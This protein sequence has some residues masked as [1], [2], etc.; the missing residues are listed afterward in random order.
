MRAAGSWSRS[1]SYMGKGLDLSR[2]DPKFL[3]SGRFQGK[4]YAVPWTV[5]SFACYYDTVRLK[6]FGVTMPD[7]RWT[8]DDL[9]TVAREIKKKAPEGYAAVADKGIWEPMLE[10]FL[11]Q[12]GQGPLHRGRPVGLH[13]GG[14]HRLFR[15]VGQP[16]AGR[17]GACGRRDHP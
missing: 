13:A 3:D 17:A 9:R 4:L 6:E 1:T 12:R 8:W 5:N 2:F 16:T 15:P 7:W 14:H 10:F 11:R